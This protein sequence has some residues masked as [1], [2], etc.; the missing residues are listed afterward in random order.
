MCGVQ[1]RAA[2][3]EEALRFV[4]QGVLD[5]V[6]DADVRAHVDKTEIGQGELSVG[7]AMSVAEDVVSA[8]THM[9][10]L[11]HGM[12]LINMCGHKYAHNTCATVGACGK[13][14][15]VSHFRQLLVFIL[16]CLVVSVLRQGLHMLMASAG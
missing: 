3:L 12:C 11:L 8:V 6:R 14:L 16:V 15:R 5:M 10:R 7:Q 2:M 1:M 9:A 4:R 13:C